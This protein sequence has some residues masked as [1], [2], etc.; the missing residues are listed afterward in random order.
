V[1]DRKVSI[2]TAGGQQPRWARSGKEL[3][4][5]VGAAVMSVPVDP[6]GTTF[7]AGTPEML[8]NGPFD[9]S[10][11]Q[12]AIAPDGAH[13]IMVEIDPNARPTQVHVV[14]NWTEEVKRLTAAS[15][16]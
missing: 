2:S 13:F 5:V 15:R 8:F 7:G 14:L 9:T 3:F 10:Y 6:T 11:T 12:Y 4:Y 16:P 1:N